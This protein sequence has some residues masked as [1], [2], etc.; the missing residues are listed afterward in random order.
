LLFWQFHAWS[1]QKIKVSTHIQYF[2]LKLGP[3]DLGA[4]FSKTDF[5]NQNKLDKH[6]WK[7]MISVYLQMY[8][9]STISFYE[10]G[11]QVM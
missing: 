2:T 6:T 10:C 7:V 3:Q 1:T 11:G 9:L 5:L 4:Y 8:R